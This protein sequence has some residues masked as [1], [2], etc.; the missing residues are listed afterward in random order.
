MPYRY[1]IFLGLIAMN[2]YSLWALDSLRVE[3]RKDQSF[4]VHRV[5]PQETLYGISK[6][7]D[8]TT[9]E[10]IKFNSATKNGLKMYQEL[11]IPIKKQEPEKLPLGK[12]TDDGQVW[13]VVKTGETLFGI[14]KMYRLSVDSLRRINGL[15]NFNIDIGDTLWLAIP[16]ANSTQPD[17][18][19]S[20]DSSSQRDKNIHIVAASETLFSISKIYAVR[21]NELVEWNQLE[22]FEISIGQQ[23][24]IRSDSLANESN[25]IIETDSVITPQPIKVVPDTLFVKTNNKPFK[26]M[27][28]QTEEGTKII[29]EGF[30]MKID[31]ADPTKKYL[32][33][34][35]IAPVGTIL[36][37]KNQMNG[38]TI[39][40][41][42]V[43]KLPE[44]GLNKNVLIRLSQ[45]AFDK[46]GALDAKIPVVA[47]YISR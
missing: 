32:A 45:P 41:R 25:Q 31:L 29:N 17:V 40:V 34:H 27:T 5:E 11:L 22:S 46:L 13:H 4:I 43:G 42:V 36:E 47:S 18:L 10:I 14:A 44:T 6:K 37:V 26:G 30:A 38:R 9:T 3:H 24:I 28:R 1:C 39:F 23:L 35:R 33:L 12:L 16:E 21:V 8:V 2:S 7:Y 20:N 15:E 19:L